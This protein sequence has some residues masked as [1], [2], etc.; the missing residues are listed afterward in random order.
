MTPSLSNASALGVALLLHFTWGF[1][2]VLT[3]FLQT[4]GQLNAMSTVCVAQLLAAVFSVASLAARGVPRR[5]PDDWSRRRRLLIGLAYGAVC[6]SRATTNFLSTGFT[7]AWHITAVA[8]FGPFVTASVSR[9]ALGERLDPRIWPCVCVAVLGG[10]LVALGQAGNGS[11]RGMVQGCSVQALSMVFSATAR[12]SMKATAGRF[13]STELMLLQYLVVV[14]LTFVA[15]TPELDRA[16]RPWGSL[17]ASQFAVLVGLSFF[18]QFLAAEGQVIIIRRL[19]PANYTV[20]QPVRIVSTVV[21]GVLLLAEPVRGF[22]SWLG[23]VFIGVAISSYLFLRVKYPHDSS[24]NA[25]Y[26]SLPQAKPG[27]AVEMAPVTR[28]PQ[29]LVAHAARAF[30][31]RGPRGGDS[32]PARVEDAD[33][34]RALVEDETDDAADSVDEEHKDDDPTR[35]LV[36]RVQV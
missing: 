25:K 36:V 9:I 1:Q 32:T 13:T 18:I 14:L 12:V 29:Q 24:P 27:G 20:F 10:A 22:K 2:P 26:S 17:S 8:M 31:W 7:S 23:L 33:D 19:G 30:G 28:D 11:R 15:T 16:W 35:G 6:A 5:E 34:D 4:R 3:R 21:G